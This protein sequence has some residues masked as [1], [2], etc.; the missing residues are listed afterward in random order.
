MCFSI[1]KYYCLF[2]KKINKVSESLHTSRKRCEYVKSQLTFQNYQKIGQS[3][4]VHGTNLALSV[5]NRLNKTL[6]RKLR[7]FL[8]TS[9]KSF[10]HL[11]ESQ[12]LSSGAQLIFQN[13][14]S[15]S[16]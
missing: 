15:K 1:D 8:D 13:R 9:V 14:C 10:F 7:Q 11:M 6:N 16:I 5:I 12:N 3:F 2:C 4:T